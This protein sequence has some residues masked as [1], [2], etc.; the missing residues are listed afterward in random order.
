MHEG[1]SVTK[2]QRGLGGGC[3]QVYSPLGTGPGYVGD[4]CVGDF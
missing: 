4:L 2:P 3:S 1:H